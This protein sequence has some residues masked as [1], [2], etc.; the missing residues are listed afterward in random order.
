ML[1]VIRFWKEIRMKS[2]LF[3][4]GTRNVSLIYNMEFN[5]I[6]NFANSLQ[7]VRERISVTAKRASER[8]NFQFK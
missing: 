2:F 5:W 6:K 8:T 3:L 4:I 7:L 1:Y